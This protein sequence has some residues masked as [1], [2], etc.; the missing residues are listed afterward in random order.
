MPEQPLRRISNVQDCSSCTPM[1]WSAALGWPAASA[2]AARPSWKKSSA[3][4]AMPRPLREHCCTI[5]Y[6]YGLPLLSAVHAILKFLTVPAMPGA[7]CCMESHDYAVTLLSAAHLPYIPH[8]GQCYR[9][10]QVLAFQFQF[11]QLQQHVKDHMHQMRQPEGRWWH[12]GQ[13]DHA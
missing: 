5:S 11:P 7:Y 6:R 10:N 4:L 12:V 13:E 8:G 3:G 1:F 9:F 2:A